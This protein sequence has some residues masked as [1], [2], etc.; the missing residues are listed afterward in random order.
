MI[1]C[2]FLLVV[3]VNDVI[4][5]L[6][7]AIEACATSGDAAQSDVGGSKTAPSSYV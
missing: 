1:P 6:L 7:L 4:I 2:S 5:E 3:G